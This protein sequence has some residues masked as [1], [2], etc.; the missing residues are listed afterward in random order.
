MRLLHSTL[1][2]CTQTKKLVNLESPVPLLQIER[3]ADKPEMR[4]MDMELW[5]YQICLHNYRL[6][7]PLKIKCELIGD[8]VDH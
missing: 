4:P 3:S 1:E 5:K 8:L 2:R 6:T 7:S